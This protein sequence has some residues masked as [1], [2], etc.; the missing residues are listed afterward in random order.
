MIYS[1]GHP[2][3]ATKTMQNEEQSFIFSYQPSTSGMTSSDGCTW[4]LWAGIRSAISSFPPPRTAQTT[5]ANTIK[6][7]PA[8]R[9]ASSAY[10]LRANA[11][12]SET[13]TMTA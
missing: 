8:T 12:A 13:M 1:R 9:P 11:D 6:Q 2:P 10:L 7:Q 5:N 4:V 3:A